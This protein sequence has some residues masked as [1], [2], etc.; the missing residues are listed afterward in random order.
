MLLLDNPETGAHSP[1]YINIYDLD[2]GT[3]N[4][5]SYDEYLE[6]IDILGIM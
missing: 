6:C 1:I 2:L 3:L 4:S 5:N